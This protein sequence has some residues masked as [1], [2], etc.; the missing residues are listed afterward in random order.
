MCAIRNPNHRFLNY[1]GVRGWLFF[2]L[3]F[4]LRSIKFV[5]FRGSFAVTLTGYRCPHQRQWSLSPPSFQMLD[6]GLH[7]DQLWTEKI[8]TR[9]VEGHLTECHHL[10]HA[11]VSVKHCI[12]KSAHARKISVINPTKWKCTNIYELNQSVD[13]IIGPILYRQ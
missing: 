8:R 5:G 3:F 12:F 7:F 2:Y 10:T 11:Q 1:S 13:S 9:V 6:V 4:L